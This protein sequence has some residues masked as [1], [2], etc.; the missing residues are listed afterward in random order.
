MGP[1]HKFTVVPKNWTGAADS[2]HQRLTSSTRGSKW[3]GGESRVKSETSK[4]GKV[5]SDKKVYEVLMTFFEC[6]A[7]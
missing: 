3:R 2:H 6:G 5:L 1:M 7:M 4:D